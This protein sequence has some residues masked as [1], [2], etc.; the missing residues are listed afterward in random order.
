[1]KEK[2]KGRNINT[3]KQQQNTDSSKQTDYSKL[4]SMTCII[5]AF[6]KSLQRTYL[7][8]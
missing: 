3:Q 6:I 1:M 4:H 5:K 7:A 8:I 2:S